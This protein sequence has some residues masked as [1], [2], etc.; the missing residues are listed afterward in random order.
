MRGRVA[1]NTALLT[2][3]SDADGDTKFS[4][5]ELGTEGSRGRKRRFPGGRDGNREGIARISQWSLRIRAKASDLRQ[6][7]S[8][9]S[10]N[11]QEETEETK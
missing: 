10:G 11:E 5:Q 2:E 7:S 9:C 4:G 6:G 8:P 1:I 3:L